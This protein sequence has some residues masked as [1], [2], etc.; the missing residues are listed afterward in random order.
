M[1]NRYPHFLLC[2][3][4]PV[5]RDISDNSNLFIM[6][7]VIALDFPSKSGGSKLNEV[8]GCNIFTELCGDE[9]QEDSVYM[10]PD[11]YKEIF[12]KTR[13]DSSRSRKRL[14]VVKIYSPKTKQSIHRKYVFN[15]D[16]QGIN[17]DNLALNPASI[18]ELCGEGFKNE[19]IVGT[20]VCV[21]K[22]CKFFYYWHHP[23]HATRI[24][25]QLGFISVLLAIISIIVGLISLYCSCYCC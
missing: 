11:A 1:R 21:T 16:F 17:S 20:D 6:K 24:S 10:S 4:L 3:E 12:G 15:P 23:H 9:R 2:C 22:G 7:K 25:M 5:L 13:K 18:R 8:V 19:D 14:S